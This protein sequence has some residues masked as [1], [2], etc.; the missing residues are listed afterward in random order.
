M[1][2]NNNAQK[3]VLTQQGLDKINEEL[4]YLKT[5]KRK[6]IAKR[7]QI[8]KDLGDLKENAEYEAA[9]DDQGFLEGRI[10][11]LENM[12][13]YAEVVDEQHLN[14]DKV[15]IGSMVKVLDLATNKEI[16]FSIV[17]MNETNPKQFKI[18]TQSPI[19][20]ALLGRSLNEDVEVIIPVGKV[21]YRILEI[22]RI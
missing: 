20:Q 11:Q 2:G 7:I 13:R 22:T 9:K 21:V 10:A 19:G 5:E 17:G 15:G 16:T 4:T 3:V 12:V 1:E 14:D 6:E 18:S 8:A